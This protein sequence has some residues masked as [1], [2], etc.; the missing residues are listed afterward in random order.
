MHSISII[1]T[2]F[3]DKENIKFCV[4]SVKSQNLKKNLEHII[5]DGGSKDGTIKIL[6]KLKKDNSH[7]R[8]YLKKN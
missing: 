2:V 8:L 3:N 6:K 4:D 1:T 5:V 7:I